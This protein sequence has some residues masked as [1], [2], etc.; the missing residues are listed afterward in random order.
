MAEDEEHQDSIDNE[1]QSQSLCSTQL[2]K[3]L[4]KCTLTRY[5]MRSTQGGAEVECILEQG[6]RLWSVPVSRQT[7]NSVRQQAHWARHNISY[8]KYVSPG[9]EDSALWRGTTKAC[10]FWSTPNPLEM[11]QQWGSTVEEVLRLKCKT[12]NMLLEDRFTW[13]CQGCLWNSHHYRRWLP[14]T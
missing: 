5:T 7:I 1:E 9:L 12:K 3:T 4:R 8:W 14:A 6:A 10:S 13:T 11:Y 2:L